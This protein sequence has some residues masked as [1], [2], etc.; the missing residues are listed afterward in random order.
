VRPRSIHFWWPVSID[1][2]KDGA[3]LS[4]DLTWNWRRVN[5]MV[6]FHRGEV[7]IPLIKLWQFGPIDVRRICR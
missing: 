6:V 2:T 4:V 5:E 3:T 1:I 7:E